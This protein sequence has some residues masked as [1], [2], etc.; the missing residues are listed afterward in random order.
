MDALSPN[1]LHAGPATHRTHAAHAAHATHSGRP[2][3]AHPLGQPEASGAPPPLAEPAQAL[4][5][6]VLTSPLGHEHTSACEDSKPAAC[7]SSFMFVP[8]ISNLS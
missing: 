8:A 4:D 5:R 6:P 7:G 2:H 3:P 1:L